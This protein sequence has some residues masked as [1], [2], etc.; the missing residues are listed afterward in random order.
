MY[1]NDFESRWSTL[2]PDQKRKLLETAFAPSWGDDLQTRQRALVDALSHPRPINQSTGL[3]AALQGV[4][5]LGGQIFNGLALSDISNQVAEN[6]A[7][8]TDPS[9]VMFGGQPATQGA[10][11]PVLDAPT[12]MKTEAL[13]RALGA[14]K[15]RLGPDGM[16]L[17]PSLLPSEQY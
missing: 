1:G 16:P 2:S 12:M 10:D 13:A 5:Q 6:N 3:G 17:P 9:G 11:L 15:K 4:G 7:K 14:K 8:L